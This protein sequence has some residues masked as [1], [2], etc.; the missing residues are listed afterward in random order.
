MKNKIK[1]Y[2]KHPRYGDKPLSSNSK[3]TL[4]EVNR[5]YWGYSNKTVF[6]HTVIDADIEKQ[7]YSTFPRGL[8]VDIEE[9]CIEC[10]RWFLFYAQ[11][12]KFWYENLG[13]YIDVPCTKCVEC[14]KKIQNLKQ[15]I[16]SYEQLLGKD[17]RTAK[18]TKALKKIA[19][20]LFKSGYIKNE[21]KISQI[22]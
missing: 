12:Q 14:R 9:K 20:E 21:Q 10:K 13:I 3:Y 17:N 6:V 5:S 11:E 19:T 8:Y 16:K 2:V 1:E 7:N 15:T 22:V 4:E 18:E